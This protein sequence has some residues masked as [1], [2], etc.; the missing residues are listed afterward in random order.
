MTIK[1][2]IDKGGFTDY[3]VWQYTGINAPNFHTDSIK[4]CDEFDENAECITW[5]YMGEDE[6]DS[7]ILANSSV[8]ADFA[9]WYDDKNAIVLCILV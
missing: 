3:E 5:E 1:E 4:G 2:I 8:R 6:Y 7:T 9:E